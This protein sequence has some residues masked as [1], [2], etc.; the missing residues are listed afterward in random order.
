MSADNSSDVHDADRRRVLLA[1]DAEGAVAK[2]FKLVENQQDKTNLPFDVLFCVGAFLPGPGTSQ[3]VAAGFA[4]YVSGKK[5]AP[6]ET[7][8]V[9]SQSAAL[10][11][12]APEGKQLFEKVHFLGGFG[13]AEI[14]GL[15]V[16]YLSGHY[17]S[18]VYDSNC[19]EPFVG[20]AYTH[21]AIDSLIKTTLTKGAAPVDVLLTAEWPSHLEDKLLDDADRPCDPDEVVDWLSK[22]SLPVAE[23]SAKLQPRYHVCGNLNIFYLRPPFQ[24]P[25][26]GHVC[27]CIALG[28]VGSKG[29]PRQWMHALSLCPAG[30]MPLSVLMQRP[31]ST[32][33]CPFVS[34]S[35]KLGPSLKRTAAEMLSTDMGGEVSLESAT[36]PNRVF[37]SKLPARIDENMIEKTFHRAVKEFGRIERVKLAREDREEG[38]RCKGYGWITF[39]TE[40]AAKA[41]CDLSELLV[42]NGRPIIVQLSKGTGDGSRTQRTIQIAIEPHADCWFCLVNPKVEKHMVVCAT[43]EV[44]VA[45]ARGPINPAHALILPVKHAP[46]YAACPPELQASISA[47]VAAVR[48]M[49]REAN[50]DT[51]L[52]ERWIPMGSSAANHMMLQILPIDRKQGGAAREVMHNV[53]KTDIPGVTLTQVYSH[54]EVANFMNDDT[55]ISYVY[56]EIPGETTANGREVERYVFANTE[57]DGKAG[58]R[59]PIDIGRRVACQLLGCDSKLDWRRCQEDKEAERRLAKTFRERFKPYQ[60]A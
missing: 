32:T 59:I 45:T 16:A 58:I 35:K 28:K 43:P 8:F 23:L 17:D 22:S 41:A 27:R 48:E 2:L 53:I 9:E 60:P 50:Y 42:C 14:R 26:A 47:H 57:A 36:V 3:G 52:W 15:R 51:L 6:V 10:L 34:G 55:T 38:G 56:F 4:E 54:T 39:D 1:G 13:V 44:Y 31:D 7:Y 33:P 49:F 19:T 30:L 24:T 40:E 21:H 11:Q 29:K 46:C 37:I 5:Q 25:E 20:A 12:T 18:K